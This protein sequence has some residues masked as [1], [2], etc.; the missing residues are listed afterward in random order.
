MGTTCDGKKATTSRNARTSSISR[1]LKNR[2]IQKEPIGVNNFLD[3]SCVLST[4]V[5]PASDSQ[6]RRLP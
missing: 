6:F 1:E 4:P 5:S 3:S 2:N